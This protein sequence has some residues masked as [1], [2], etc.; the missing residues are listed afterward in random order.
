MYFKGSMLARLV[1]ALLTTSVALHQHGRH[2]RSRGKKIVDDF[3][4]IDLPVVHVAYA[5]TPDGF[6]GLLHSMI[7]VARNFQGK[8][9]HIHVIVAEDHITKASDVLAC[10]ERDVANLTSVTTASLHVMP[11]LPWDTSLMRTSAE[12]LARSWGHQDKLSQPTVFARFY[13]HE[14][15]SDLPKVLWLDVDTIVTTDV[16]D[17]F[18]TKM[19]TP[20]AA[21][22]IKKQLVGH[23]FKGWSCTKDLDQ[24]HQFMTFNTG[25]MVLDLNRWREGNFTHQLER[26]AAACVTNDQPTFNIVFMDKIQHFEKSWNTFA[27]GSTVKARTKRVGNILHWSGPVK[28]WSEPEKCRNPEVR[29][30]DLD[31]LSAENR[32]D[33]DAYTPRETCPA[34]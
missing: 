5:T 10:F 31:C 13:L 9:C 4:S 11:A 22:P 32:A 25:V 21:R 20:L 34:I 2:G 19:T 17:L 23:E 30:D 29:K 14:I 27:L 3:F 12:G 33:Y 7:S 28:P 18:L 24:K 6:P 16:T 8:L 26:T 1:L 15:L